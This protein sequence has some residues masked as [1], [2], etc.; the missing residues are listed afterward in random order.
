MDLFRRSKGAQIGAAAALVAAIA[1]GGWFLLVKPTRQDAKK[2]AVEI[3][4]VETQVAKRKEE[5][6]KPYAQ[7]EIRASDLYR[8][9][10]AIPDRSDMSGVLLQLDRLAK[11]NKVKLQAVSPGSPV[12]GAG[13]DEL[14]I[15]VEVRGRFADVSSFLGAAQRLTRVKKGHL[16]STGRLYVIKSVNLAQDAERG[17]PSVSG[18]LGLSAYVFTGIAPALPTAPQADT[19]GEQPPTQSAS[20]A[21]STEAAGANP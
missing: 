8:L 13:F 19:T 1:V 10:R 12:A 4:A 15:A 17:F 16:D 14:P 11:G 18:Q 2:L 21:G 7:V 5:L 20:P 6:A 9:T 3:A